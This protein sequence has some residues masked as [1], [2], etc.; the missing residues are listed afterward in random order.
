M[1]LSNFDNPK[2][3]KAETPLLA[4]H[5]N[6]F[7]RTY[8]GFAGDVE[9]KEY[10]NVIPISHPG[11]AAYGNKNKASRVFEMTMAI[12]SAKSTFGVQDGSGRLKSTAH[13][14]DLPQDCS[15]TA[16]AAQSPDIEIS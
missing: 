5:G 16:W 11:A 10:A 7:L 13:V 9:K 14:P 8:S 12:V 3:L 6:P 2:K 4:S 1:A 15:A